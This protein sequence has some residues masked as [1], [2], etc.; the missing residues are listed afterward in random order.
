MHLDATEHKGELVFLHRVKDGPANQSYGLV[1]AGLAGVPRAVIDEARRYLA[2][3]D[4]EQAGAMAHGP[5][6]AL[7]FRAVEAA[8]GV[9]A[10]GDTG[11]TGHDAAGQA[12][13][14][15]LSE[16]DVDALSPRE[17]LALLYE[18]VETAA[19]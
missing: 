4:T 3:L 7:D 10:A 19:E 11:G 9:D 18:L 5:Q 14:L 8:G 1:V 15:R 16:L 13:K 12:L 6:R 2:T 17:A